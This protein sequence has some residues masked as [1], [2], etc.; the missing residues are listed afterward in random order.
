MLVA[1]A[2]AIKSAKSYITANLKRT[3]FFRMRTPVV[4]GTRAYRKHVS[5]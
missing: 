1:M 3:L 2:T 5:L 4:I